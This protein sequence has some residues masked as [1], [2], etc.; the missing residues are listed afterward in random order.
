MRNLGV[1][2]AQTIGVLLLTVGVFALVLGIA[3]RETGLFGLLFRAGGGYC[4]LQGA[5]LLLEA[6][7]RG[8]RGS[9]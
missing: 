1:A 9:R 7:W 3:L 2:A 6:W 4:V 5:F 8:R